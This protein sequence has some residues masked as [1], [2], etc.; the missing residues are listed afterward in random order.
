M[1]RASLLHILD[2]VS[3]ISEAEI[4]ELEQL[5]AAFPYCQTAHVLLAKAAH[6]QGSML[7]SQRLR[8]AATYAT[9]RQLLRQLIEQPAAAHLL[10]ES[11]APVA[12]AVAA[13]PPTPQQPT[14]DIVPTEPA[15]W[16]AEPAGAETET[17]ETDVEATLVNAA[18]TT[19]AL[20]LASEVSQPTPEAPDVA[21]LPIEL[22]TAEALSVPTVP[23]EAA[24]TAPF[25][26]A[27][28]AEE[29]A[30]NPED[31]FPEA[32]PAEAE[33]ELTPDLAAEPAALLVESEP[34]APE[35]APPAPDDF[36]VPQLPE[37]A[38]EE[39]LEA[40]A[41]AVI[42]E[43]YPLEPSVEDT[44]ELVSS[45]Q[46]LIL[47]ADLPAEPPV[48]VD[49]SPEEDILPPVAPPIRPPV[50][51]GTSR[52][53]FGLSLPEPVEPIIYELP[54]IE[55]EEPAEAP[56]V[57]AGFRG[58]E[59]LGYALGGGSRLGF[60][61]Q[62]ADELAYPLP[63][64]EFF[65]PDALLQEQ[66]PRYRPA[67]VPAPSPFDLINKF[68]RNQPRLRTPAVLP[69]S[70]EEQADLS[71]RSTQGVPDLASE[72]LARIMVRQGKIQ[73]AIEIYER[74]MMRQ[75]EKKAYFADQIQQLK[76]TE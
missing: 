74:L 42:N 73:K 28:S 24:D 8:R 11:V 40:P 16:I 1:T 66:T 26:S 23:T 36:S 17:G 27:E 58:D 56:E 10:P 47:P 29:A 48:P 38:D 5:A 15:Q 30:V 44:T 55:E 22:S 68:L 63:I 21:V 12:I 25:I 41:E 18:E 34:L 19:P 39:P 14:V 3:T 76:S 57:A 31:F 70:A 60:C 4:R 6:D 72:S 13:E 61:L 52:F 64:T 51:A 7:A 20:E 9:D 59:L 67:P 75:P 2:H 62:Q 35:V 69:A 49:E 46:E 71:V 54:T 65:A 43:E 45:S 53:E 33:Q 32:A 37:V 50:E